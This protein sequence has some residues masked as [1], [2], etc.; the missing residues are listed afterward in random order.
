MSKLEF[1][2]EITNENLLQG[3][4]SINHNQI[5]QTENRVFSYVLKSKSNIYKLF[6]ICCTWISLTLI[7]YGVS[8][9]KYLI[10]ISSPNIF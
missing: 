5:K 4:N 3:A 7:Y 1:I 6:A 10:L 8:L 2:Q 9:G